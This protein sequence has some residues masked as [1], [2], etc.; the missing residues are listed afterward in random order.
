MRFEIL[1]TGQLLYVADPVC[2]ERFELATLRLY[3]DTAWLR[4]R[5]QEYLR[6]RMEQWS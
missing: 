2:R 3:R 4:R 6:E 5:Q 1:R